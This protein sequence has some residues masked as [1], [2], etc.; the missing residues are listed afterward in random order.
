MCAF[1][2]TCMQDHSL[3]SSAWRASSF[4]DPNSTVRMVNVTTIDYHTHAIEGLLES[5]LIKI[6]F[7]Q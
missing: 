2:P 3:E 4:C 7:P 5:T 1:S 6:K